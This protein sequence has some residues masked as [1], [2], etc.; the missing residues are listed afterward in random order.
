M[1]LT[2]E[3]GTRFREIKNQNLECPPY[4]A[5]RQA[6]VFKDL[7]L[8][9]RLSGFYYHSRIGRTDEHYVFS[10]LLSNST[11]GLRYA[12]RMQ[13]AEKQLA[14][15]QGLSAPWY[16][17]LPIAALQSGS[18]WVWQYYGDDPSMLKFKAI[19]EF[20]HSFDQA[21]SSDREKW[22]SAALA[23]APKAKLHVADLAGFAA[24]QL[25]RKGN[26]KDAFNLVSRFQN[27][28]NVAPG[29]RM[30]THE[31]FRSVP[32]KSKAEIFHYSDNGIKN[33]GIAKVGHLGFLCKEFTGSGFLRNEIGAR[34][35]FEFAPI[36]LVKPGFQLEK[37]G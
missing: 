29:I 31:L 7:E 11:L 28:S 6:L 18:L 17:D 14:R 1:K 36:T 34:V 16:V 33:T 9:L 3:G 21:K 30:A 27:H 19:S 12:Y 2:L 26:L 32:W 8:A 25:L 37:C 10:L 15:S 24:I 35:D 20:F 13:E 5:I 22:F 4:Q 23:T